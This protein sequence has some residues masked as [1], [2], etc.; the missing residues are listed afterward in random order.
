MLCR[1][2]INFLSTPNQPN[3][4]AAYKNVKDVMITFGKDV[5]SHSAPLKATSN[6]EDAK[7]VPH[8]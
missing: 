2:S 7:H 8:T 1:Y 6:P 5:P 3:T 4:I